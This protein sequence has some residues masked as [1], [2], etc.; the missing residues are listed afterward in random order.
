MRGS[1]DT[2]RTCNFGQQNESMGMIFMF[3]QRLLCSSIATV[4]ALGGL[5]VARAQDAGQLEEIVVTGVRASLEKAQEIKRESDSILDAIVAEDI[6]KLPDLTAAESIARIPGV[7]VSRY[8]DEASTVLVRGLPDVTTT[9]NGREFFTAELRRVQLQDFPSQAL[10]GIEVYKSGTADLIEPGLAGV[11]NV[12]TRRPFDFEGQKISASVHHSY[13]D[14]SEKS[15]PSGNLLY[16]NR[17]NT[18]LGEFGALGNVSYAESAYYNGVRYNA[19]WFPQAQAQWNIEQPYSDGGFILPATVGLYNSSGN[20][21]RPSANVALQFRPNDELNFYFD[22]IYQGYRGRGMADNF[23]YPLTDSDSLNGTPNLSNIVMV[24]GTDN[25][26]AAALTKSGGVPP[27]AFRST[28]SGATD[29]YQYAIGAQ[30]D[31]GPLKVVTDLAYTDSKYTNDEWSFDTGLAMSPTVNASFFGDQGAIFDSQW[32]VTDVSLYEVRGYFEKMYAVAGKGLQWRTDLTFDTGLDWLHTVQ[33]GV[34][35][36]DR[37][38]SM[39]QGSRYAPLWESHI[40]V[41]ALGFLDM[42]LTHDPYRTN[43]QGFTQYLAPTRGSIAGNHDA[44]AR[45]AHEQLLASGHS[46]ANQWANPNITIDPASNWLANEKSYAAYLQGK[47]YFE[48]GSTKVDLF[49]GVRVVRTEAINRGTSTVTLDGVS[50]QEPRTASNS[51][52]DVFPNI[53]TR[54]IFTDELQ[55]R[56]GFT[57]TSTKPGFGDMNPALNI[58]QIVQGANAPVLE[59]DAEGWGGNPDLKPLTSDN[60]DVSLEYYFSKAGFVTAAVFYR[61][62]FGFT[63]RYTR[64][65]EDPAYGTIRFTRPEN[66]GEGRIKGWELSAST[67]LDFAF[68][69]DVLKPFGV[70]VNAT[71]L[72]GENRLPDGDGNFGDFVEIPGLSKLTY[73]AAVFYE[74]SRF[75]ARLSYNRRDT[76]VN[77]YGQTSANGGF[78]GNKTRARDRLDFSSRFNATDHIS[79][80]ADVGNVLAR[81]FRNFTVIDGYSYPQDVRDEGRYFGVGIQVQY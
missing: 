48:L 9:Y 1:S 47:S 35:Y 28:N 10:A 19:T 39:K 6:G 15:A 70:S 59:F 44:L 41:S 36:N 49:A 5:Q 22:G 57:Q 53:S 81:P 30:W 42:Q 80:W 27:Q 61:D 77:W 58:T 25:R 56:A 26:Q 11:V 18:E 34:R 69:P 40:P 38:A 23:W 16:S 52:V 33:V 51:Y 46:A 21:R 55:L 79:I 78:A 75:S 72:E 60:Y 4:T 62:L 63:N 24:D 8:D 68:I 14:Q 74:L 37:D 65:I 45:V 7:Q 13:N 32:D 54:V 29:T 17:W 31:H 71:R 20:R 3:K 12:R 2:T 73:N 50:R 66:A 76:W 67:F 43:R 64:F